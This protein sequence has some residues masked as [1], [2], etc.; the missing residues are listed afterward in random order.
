MVTRALVSVAA[1]AA[2]VAAIGVTADAQ[3]G[4]IL[5]KPKPGVAKPAATQDNGLSCSGVTDETIDK[6]LKA[7][8]AWQDVYDRD[9]AQANARQAEADAMAKKRAQGT[10]GTLMAT[11]ECTDKFK[12]KDPRSR[13]IAR[14]E[15]LVADAED[16]GDEAKADALR[17]K[18]D[19]LSDALNV[20]ADRACGGKGAAALHDCLA[21][22]KVDL[23]KTGLTE[24]MLT[25][26]AQGE[27]MSDPATSGIAGATAASA[28]EE[29]ASKGAAEAMRNAR[30]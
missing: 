25:I 9:M 17:K 16:K 5:K 11:A 8:K 12:E 22:K 7:R 6:Y 26:Q 10:F 29:A 1:A 15:Q 14:L 3:L 19:P 28:E 30:D 20:D 23:A 2:F 24:P 18:L 13:E 21:K 4:G 27:C